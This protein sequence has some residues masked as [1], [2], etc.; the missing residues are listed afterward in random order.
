MHDMVDNLGSA[1]A[2]EAHAGGDRE[3]ETWDSARDVDA[4]VKALADAIKAA[5]GS[6]IL[7]TGAGIST[8]A[9]VPDY[10]SPLNTKLKTGPGVWTLKNAQRGAEVATFTEKRCDSHRFAAAVRHR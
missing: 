5:D 10:H 8:S 1:L 9:G 3:A 6:V 4:K 7:F 2:V